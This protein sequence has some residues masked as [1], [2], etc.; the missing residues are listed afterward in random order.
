MPSTPGLYGR[1]QRRHGHAGVRACIGPIG[2]D[3]RDRRPDVRARGRVGGAFAG[4]RLEA[5]GDREEDR[6][7][8]EHDDELDQ[9]ESVLAPART[10]YRRRASLT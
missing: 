6:H 3:R 9:R 5:D 4:A 2:L 10:A 1:L 8:H 7:D